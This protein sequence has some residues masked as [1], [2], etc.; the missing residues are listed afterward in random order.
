M[1][2]RDLVVVSCAFLV[3][4]PASRFTRSP[5]DHG[6]RAGDFP[7][8]ADGKLRQVGVRHTGDNGKFLRHGACLFCWIERVT[9]APVIS[10]RASC[11]GRLDYSV[12]LLDRACCALRI[13][14]SRVQRNHGRRGAGSSFGA[15][16]WFSYASDLD[17]DRCSDVTFG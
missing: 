3:R 10:M 8:E 4:R 11:S 5:M 1:P 13:G 14:V 16:R 7:T 9:E 17:G 6:L 2:P 12:D 15:G